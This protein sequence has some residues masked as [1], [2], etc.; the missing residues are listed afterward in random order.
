[1]KREKSTGPIWASLIG[2][3]IAGAYL[4][5]IVLPT[6]FAGLH[7]MGASGDVMIAGVCVGLAY[8]TYR[9]LFGAARGARSQSAAALK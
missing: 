5:P 7:G 1:M 3:M 8:V 6:G 9:L 4:K 2:G